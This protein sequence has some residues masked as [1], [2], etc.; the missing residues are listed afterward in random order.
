MTTIKWAAAIAI[1][2]LLC[3]STAFAAETPPK[4]NAKQ[5]TKQA[6]AQA[7]LSFQPKVETKKV[8]VGKRTFTVQTVTLPKE[9]EASVGLP[10]HV[11]GKTGHLKDIV[12]LSGARFG[13]NGT[14]FEAYGGAP[15]PWG[16]IIANG[17]VEH[18]GNTGT[19]VGFTDDGNVLMDHLRIKISGTVTSPAE[20]K[21]SWYVYF[22]NRT[23][24]ENGNGAILFTPKRGA[25]IG[26]KFGNAVVVEDG[27]VTK[28][29]N[30]ENAAI[31]K[32]GYVL[33]F[34]GV[35]ASMADRF[36][37]GSTVEY[38][39]SYQNL[40]GEEIPW[41]NV[42]TAIGAGP[43]LVKDGKLAVNPKEEGFTSSKI[44]TDGGARSGI[45]VKKDG[46]VVLA[47]VGGATMKQWAEIMLKLGAQQAMNLDGGASSGLFADGK[48]VT[49]PGRL[50]GNALVFGKNESK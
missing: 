4:Q 21:A 41:E 40:K 43:R 17:Q 32:N 26:F 11:V 25:N 50:I 45:A 6:A 3:A 15:E 49:A 7:K 30:N 10:N 9:M 39:V 20:K 24:K 29:T 37:V 5:E 19:A 16:T 1:F 34:V 47:T 14:Y 35:E 28:V 12:N 44:V 38:K 23:P 18:I 36:E 13:I 46:S 2:S 8:T 33:V 31:P 48:T 42:T 27:V 22:V